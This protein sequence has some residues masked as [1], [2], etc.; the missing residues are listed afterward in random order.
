VSR[1]TLVLGSRIDY[2]KSVPLT[3]TLPTHTATFFSPRV[4]AAFQVSD[5]VSLQAASYRSSRT[6]SLNELH[7]GFRVGNA[8]T[9]ANPLLDPEQLTG[10]EGGVLFTHGWLSARATGFF[11]QLENAI[12]N[13]TLTTTPALIT[14]ERQNT[15]TVRASGLEVEADIRPSRRWTIGGVAVLTRSRFE[16]TP[17][18][19][20]LEGNRVPQVPRFQVGGTLTY[21]DPHGF[22]GSVQSRLFGAQFDDDLNQFEL[23]G[24]SVTDVSL[25]QQVLRRLNVFFAVENL[26]DEDYDTGRTPLR[27][28]GWPRTA[29]VGIRVFLP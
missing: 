22:T 20:A 17:A 19:P 28:I 5:A 26:F 9:R 2:W 27:T 12:T 24:Y 4:S 18:Q 6:P 23:K 21:V 7:R 10:V 14:R 1:L 15:D 3:T 25:S 8:V 13:V 11:N 16:E 29:R